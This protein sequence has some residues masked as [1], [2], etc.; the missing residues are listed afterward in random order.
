M[1]PH[2]HRH[3]GERV[4]N[5]LGTENSPGCYFGRRTSPNPGGKEAIIGTYAVT[6]SASGMGLQAARRLTD[7]GHTVIG[8]DLKEGDVIADLSTPRGRRMAADGVLAAV[9]QALTART[10]I[11]LG[12]P[13]TTEAPEQ[14]G[15]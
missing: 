3:P 12:P 13:E 14:P 10:A 6:G 11:A 5:R 7:L 8:V 2:R 9:T 4:G 1:T 15:P